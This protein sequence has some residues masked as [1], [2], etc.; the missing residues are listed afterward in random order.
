MPRGQGAQSWVNGQEKFRLEKERT[1]RPRAPSSTP[2]PIQNISQEQT[3][4]E[5]VALTTRTVGKMKGAG[6]SRDKAALGK[7]RSHLPAE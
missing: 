5:L 6:G 4:Q 7:Q 3:K 1:A 2:F